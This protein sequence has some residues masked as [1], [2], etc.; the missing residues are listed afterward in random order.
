MPG[1]KYANSPRPASPALSDR[2]DATDIQRAPTVQQKSRL[3]RLPIEQIRPVIRIAHQL[4]GG[5]TIAKRIIVDYEI[6]LLIRGQSV[7]HFDDLP[8]PLRPGNLVVIPPFVEHAFASGTGELIEHVAVH[9]DL[10]QT[11]PGTQAAARSRA[12][13]VELSHGQSF[14]TCNAIPAGNF[15]RTA[16][17][18]IIETFPDRNPAGELECSSL[19]GSV[20]AFLLSQKALSSHQSSGQSHR[21]R[22][23]HLLAY[24]DEHLGEPL[25]GEYLAIQMDLSPSR[26]RTIFGR[27][28]GVSPHQYLTQR[29]IEKARRLLADDHH[30][31]KQIARLTGFAD[32]FHF[33]KTFRHIDGLPPS[34][35]RTQAR[36]SRI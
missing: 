15:V 30:T 20:L 32:E 29:R 33:S 34:L 25:D 35:Y 28:M 9:F 2:A 16:F 17:S 22:L 13:R 6:V 5:L 23:E 36:A 7:L 3:Y 11:I 12:Y 1:K 18:R 26:F 8:V 19:L 10:S 4:T 27:M 24:I 14:P 31:I 21:M